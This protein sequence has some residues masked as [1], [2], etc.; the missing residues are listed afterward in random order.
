TEQLRAKAGE[1][2]P[3]PAPI[4][5]YR[6]EGDPLPVGAVPAAGVALRFGGPEVS[7]FTW[8]PA[9]GAFLRS[10]DGAPHVDTAGVQLAPA[11]VVVLEIQY[12]FSGGSPHGITT[13]DG[14]ALVFTAGHVVDGRWVRPGPGDPLQ[15]L[16]AD[17]TPIALTPGQ[18]FLELPPAGGATIL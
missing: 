10:Q 8:D 3:A 6:A 11:N 2:P 18:T 4:F 12:R 15:L 13:G 16:A 5:G 7:R 14:R 17:G 9:A 1:Q